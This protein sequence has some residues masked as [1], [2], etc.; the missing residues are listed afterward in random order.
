VDWRE[1]ELA[2]DELVVRAWRDEDRN[3]IGTT[4]RDPITGRYFGRSLTGPSMDTPDPDAPSFTIV[5]SGKPI[6][7]VWFRPGVRPFEVGYFV[8][9]DWWGQGIATRALTLVA[10]WMLQVGDVKSIVLFT[11][12]ENI[13]SQRVA[14]RAGF[15][16]DGIEFD[17][18]EFKDGGRDAIRFVRTAPGARQRERWNAGR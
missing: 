1:V 13:G 12:P 10:N 15:V 14:E 8:H 9:T 2:A 11:H 16:R 7:R 5:R 6:G 3:A 18:A 17:Y 4:P